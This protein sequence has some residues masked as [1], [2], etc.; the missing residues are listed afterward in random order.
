METFLGGAETYW[1]RP[2]LTNSL[3]SSSWNFEFF[4]KLFNGRL[5]WGNGFRAL[6][7][8]YSFIEF[9]SNLV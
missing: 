9:V 1:D 7:T 5:D 8:L 2:C 4:L 3:V 6:S